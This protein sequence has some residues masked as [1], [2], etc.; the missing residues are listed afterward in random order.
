VTAILQAAAEIFATLGYAKTTTNKI[1]ARAGVSVGSLYQYFPNKDAIL[2]ALRH[3]HQEAVHEVAERARVKLRDPA[4]PLADGLEALLRGLVELHEQ[5]PGLNRLL[6]EDIR[7]LERPGD[8]QSEVNA[9]AEEVDHHVADVREILRARPDVK[10]A[11]P[12]QA[13]LILVRTV[14]SLTRWVVHEA[15]P[16]VDPRAFVREMLRMLVGY[17]EGDRAM[18]DRT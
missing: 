16:H 10:V 12:G 11:D 18:D 13:A 7:P 3:E 8:H 14:E 5:S 17:L 6:G 1:A 2:L 15:P 4:T 9:E